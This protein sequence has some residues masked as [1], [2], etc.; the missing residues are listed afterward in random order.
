MLH[1]LLQIAIV[2][3]E[4][5]AVGNVP[6]HDRLFFHPKLSDLVL[7]AMHNACDTPIERYLR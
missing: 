5:N 3:P 7:L 4:L 1:F 2:L 6:S